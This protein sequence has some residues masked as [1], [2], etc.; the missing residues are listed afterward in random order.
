MDCFQLILEAIFIAKFI[1]PLEECAGYFQHG[2]IRGCGQTAILDYLKYSK[3]YKS[4]AAAQ[5]M[6]FIDIEGAYRNVDPEMMVKILVKRISNT[7]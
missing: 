2:F 4:C 5:H 1:D 7:K 6:T 3:K